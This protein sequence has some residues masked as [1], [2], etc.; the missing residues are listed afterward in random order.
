MASQRRHALERAFATP[1]AIDVEGPAPHDI[2]LDLIPL[3]R[4]KPDRETVAHLATCIET[5]SVYNCFV[6]PTRTPVNGA[7]EPPIGSE[8]APNL[9]KP[10]GPRMAFGP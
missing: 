9:V 10:P 3:H 4:G 8:P 6:Y 1:V 7:G 2:D 5:P